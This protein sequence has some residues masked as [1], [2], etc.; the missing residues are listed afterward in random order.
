MIAGTAALTGP[1]PILGQHPP[2]PSADRPI[3]GPHEVPST[4]KH[5]MPGMRLTTFVADVT[6]PLGAAINMGFTQPAGKVEHPLYCKGVILEDDDGRTVLAAID[7]LALC[8]QSHAQFRRAL[9]EATETE[10]DRVAIHAVHQHT[11]PIGGLPSVQVIISVS[12]V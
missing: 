4:I 12:T 11:A 7:W 5:G 1:L 10:F 9:A 2:S 3:T 8:G 6:P